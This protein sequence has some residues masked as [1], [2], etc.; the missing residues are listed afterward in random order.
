MLPQDLS[1]VILEEDLSEDTSSLDVYDPKFEEDLI[2][3]SGATLSS[4]STQED[5]GFTDSYQST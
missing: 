2:N 3:M 4:G 1:G 5:F